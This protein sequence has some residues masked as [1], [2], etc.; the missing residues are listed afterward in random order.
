MCE[1]GFTLFKPV[2]LRRNLLHAKTTLKTVRFVISEYLQTYYQ[3]QISVA[4][5]SRGNRADTMRCARLEVRVH[6][7]AL[8]YSDH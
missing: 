7:I 6:E 4:N 5:P 1:R 3:K 2:Q 8:N